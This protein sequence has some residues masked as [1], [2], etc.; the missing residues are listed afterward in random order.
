[1]KEL[2]PEQ[3]EAAIVLKSLWDSEQA[4]RGFKQADASR[5][6]GITQPNI[7]GF[8]NQKVPLGA[9]SVAKLAKFLGVQPSVIMPSLAYLDQRAQDLI[10]LESE[11]GGQAQAFAPLLDRHE[12]E[13]WLS[14]NLT[15]D[16][17]PRTA[18]KIPI[19]DRWAGKKCFAVLAT[20]QDA[21]AHKSV[22]VNDV[23]ICDPTRRPGAGEMGLYD[24]AGDWVLGNLQRH[25]GKWVLTFDTFDPIPLDDEDAARISTVIAT[26]RLSAPALQSA[27]T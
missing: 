1:M 18:N 8:L 15:Y 9:L 22:A 25:A 3:I 6:T 27:L 7:S 11:T 20:Q 13:A 24:I 14:G 17:L 19:F 12:A 4:R 16:S 2:T 21:A 5:E 26:Y 10:Q 23:L